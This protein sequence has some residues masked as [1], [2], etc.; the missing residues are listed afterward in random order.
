M[1][2]RHFGIYLAWG[3]TVDL[4]KEGLGRLLLAF[5]KAAAMREDVRFVIACP[6]WSRKSLLALLES[7]GISSVAF[8]VVS[9]D[10]VPLILRVVLAGRS[11]KRI[12]RKPSRLTRLA[13][14][15][16]AG[17]VRHRQ[18]IE[19]RLVAT[20]RVL[21]W[22]AITGY[23]L[24]LGIL[25][26]PL[27]A[28]AWLGH[29]AYR[30]FLRAAK[31]LIRFRW[32]RAVFR[33]LTA[34][35]SLPGEEA[36]EI[37]LY[38]LMEA[39]EGERLADLVNAMRHVKAWY[40]PTAFWPAFNRVSAPRLMC[41][42]DVVPTDFPVG[43]SLAD[44]DLIKS[45]EIVERAIGGGE[46]FVTYSS[47][48]KWDTLV[49]RY[50]VSP[51]AVSVIP[52]A[53]WDLNHLI[54]VSGF[55]DGEKATKTYCESLLKQALIRLGGSAYAV[56]LASDSIRFLF[57]P[58]Q[59]RPNKNLVTLLRAYEHLLRERFIPQKLILTGNLPGLK[60]V[61]DF[62]EEHRLENDVLCLH[63]LTTR[64]LAACYRLTDLAVNPSLSE[65][66]CPFT[67]TEALSVGTPVVM[68]RIPVTEDV[69]LD[70]TLREIMLFDPY[71]WQDV[72]SRIE[73]ALQHR[74]LLL[75]AQREFYLQLS[76]RTWRNV[77]DDYVD[78]LD[79][80]A[81]SSQSAAEKQ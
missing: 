70:E 60:P 24:L 63:G 62:I 44:P 36:L 4:Q 7:E 51:T 18:K 17:V 56:G 79:G 28:V 55:P 52:H 45:V 72:A 39:D 59:F 8:D 25:L 14:R 2:L 78:I 42:P 41:V 65:G 38:R 22:V 10:G 46:N 61:K 68:A 47:R 77:V 73:W 64:E 16:Q 53:C 31:A 6:Q 34:V 9:T 1:S 69:I 75:S 50:S 66:G 15:I 40:C 54:E 11:R 35:L 58:T 21:P 80:L 12:P 27:V 3:P 57:Y 5:L 71:N 67:L 26:L 30:G 13:A 19:R 74:E 43:F 81:A 37:R 29:A 33:Q 76:Q 49:D 20:R 48:V 23:A 32:P